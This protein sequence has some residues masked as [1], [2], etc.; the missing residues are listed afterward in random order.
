[1]NRRIKKEYILAAFLLVAIATTVTVVISTTAK[2]P[3]KAGKSSISAELDRE[4]AK[5]EKSQNPYVDLEAKKQNKVEENISEESNAYKEIEEVVKKEE[6]KKNPDEKAPLRFIYPLAKGSF[7]IVDKYDA[8]YEGFNQTYIE[9]IV[10]SPS[11]GSG[12]AGVAY[13]AEGVKDV[14]AMES[15]T[16]LSIA[17]NTSKNCGYSVVLQH[18]SNITTE[19]FC[20]AKVDVATGDKVKRGAKIGSVGDIKNPLIKDELR[21]YMLESDKIVNPEKYIVK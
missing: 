3:K 19:Y 1:M 5:I 6:A 18:E 13:K 20:L 21:I 2:S 9:T 15:A 14:Y 11:F 10:F 16:V 17:D 7:K 8:K 4:L 12:I